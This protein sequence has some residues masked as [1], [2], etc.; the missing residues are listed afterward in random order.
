MHIA[1]WKA[2]LGTSPFLKKE[3]PEM[4]Q[5]VTSFGEAVLSKTQGKQM[6]LELFGASKEYHF[7]AHFGTPPNWVLSGNSIKFWKGLRENEENHLRNP[8]NLA[9]IF[10]IEGGVVISGPPVGPIRLRIFK[11]EGGVFRGV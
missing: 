2:W 3:G 10:K 4:D 5:K 6:L 11:I 1:K 7:R 9:R 8:W